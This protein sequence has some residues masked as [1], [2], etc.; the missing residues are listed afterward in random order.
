MRYVVECFVEVE[1]SDQTFNTSL[2]T[3]INDF[4]H[5]QNHP[6]PLWCSGNTLVSHT[7]TPG[8]IPGRGFF[9]SLETVEN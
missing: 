7:D 1:Q 8:S 9:F 3:V 4:F 5:D 6:N 2:F